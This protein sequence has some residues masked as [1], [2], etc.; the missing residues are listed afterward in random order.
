MAVSPLIIF[1]E[2]LGPRDNS[3]DHLFRVEVSPRFQFE[4]PDTWPIDHS[5]FADLW[6]FSVSSYLRSLDIDTID[7]HMPI[8]AKRLSILSQLFQMEQGT[9][10][11]PS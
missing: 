10:S 3:D 7:L 4:I 2:A 9:V 5:D 1:W 6:V 11:A 8:A